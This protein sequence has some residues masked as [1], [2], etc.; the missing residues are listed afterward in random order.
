MIFEDTAYSDADSIKSN[1][2]IYL[3][4]RDK[5]P[6]LNQIEEDPKAFDLL[7]SLLEDNVQNITDGDSESL[8][9]L[10]LLTLLVQIFQIPAVYA[11][12]N[13]KFIQFFQVCLRDAESLKELNQLLELCIQIFSFDP[14]RETIPL[15]SSFYRE[16]FG[17]QQFPSIETPSEG[18]FIDL[19]CSIQSVF[20][21][22]KKSKDTSQAKSFLEMRIRN[23]L[24]EG[25]FISKN[26]SSLNQV[27]LLKLKQEL[28]DILQL[29]IAEKEEADKIIRFQEQQEENLKNL[30]KEL[31]LQ[32]R[33]YFI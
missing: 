27:F 23:I 13:S 10:E 7:I 8:F 29:I 18:T 2:E 4:M 16:N 33:T 14:E 32:F 12:E 20:L 15:I 26:Y 1:L 22:R 9:L 28:E 11:L 5:E 24:N 21:L 6:I 17:V 19:F 25:Q 31:Q 30:S 3:A